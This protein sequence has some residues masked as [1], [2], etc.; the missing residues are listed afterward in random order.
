MLASGQVRFAGEGLIGIGCGLRAIGFLRAETKLVDQC[1][2][3][4]DGWVLSG[5]ELVAVEDGICAGEETDCLRLLGKVG[6]A[7]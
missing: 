3:F 4:F 7:G 1:E 5:K 2:V 6:A